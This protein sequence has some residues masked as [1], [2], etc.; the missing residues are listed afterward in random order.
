MWSCGLVQC[1][2]EH[3]SVS[4][5]NS[6]SVI[7]GEQCRCHG[8]VSQW[9]KA[10]FNFSQRLLLFVICRH[11]FSSIAASSSP[12]R[13]ITRIVVIVIFLIW[14]NSSPKSRSVPPLHIPTPASTR[15]YDLFMRW[16]GECM[17]ML[18]GL[19]SYDVQIE[20]GNFSP[21]N[22]KG[23]SCE[24]KTATRLTLLSNGDFANLAFFNK[25]MGFCNTNCKRLYF[26]H[27][28]T[29]FFCYCYCFVLLSSTLIWRLA[30]LESDR[31][32]GNFLN[33]WICRAVCDSQ[34]FQRNVHCTLSPSK[35]Y[36]PLHNWVHF[37]IVIIG[38]L[39]LERVM[40]GHCC[41]KSSLL[42]KYKQAKYS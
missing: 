42:L 30:S 21:R 22:V 41:F 15:H 23:V 11:D 27:I 40:G 20:E 2:A 6:V 4:S 8:W 28:G 18:F 34:L 26:N 38:S 7:S 37:E 3:A 31:Y 5:C 25:Q 29:I 32:W 17:G 39:C 14:I 1:S 33:L 35:H 13:I 19:S 16:E 12:I 36:A 9:G 24:Q 10:I